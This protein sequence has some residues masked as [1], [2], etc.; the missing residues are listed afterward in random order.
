METFWSILPLALIL[1]LGIFVQASAGFAA[2][3]III[4]SLLWCG[5]TIPEAQASML[6]ATIPQNIGGVWSL[7]DSISIKRVALPGATRVA[8][9]PLGCFVLVGLQSF[10]IDR[11][12]QVVGAVVL[13]VTIAIIVFKPHPQPRLH[14]VWAILAFPAS[15]FLQ[16][17][18]G[19][20]GPAMVFW[21]QAHDW[22][23]REIRGFLFAMYLI[24]ILPAMVVLYAFFG[25]AI[26]SP[27]IVAAMLIPLLLLVTMFGLK[28]GDWLGRQRLRRITLS[29]L[30]LIGIAGIA[31]PY[32][33]F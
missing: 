17:L 23:T 31:S 18:V 32:L 4:P 13:L 9:L 12:K 30:L 1:C 24:S 21:V 5:L 6:I 27:S 25:D 14:R 10:P 20:G 7:R 29:L 3:L 33:P 16:G 2:G 28:F 15:G 26:V 11:V 22:S 19:M 8:F